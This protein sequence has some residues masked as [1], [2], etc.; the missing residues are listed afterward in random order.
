MRARQFL[1]DVLFGKHE[2]EIL[3]LKPL[4]EQMAHSHVDRKN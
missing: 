3:S 4:I 1:L 2:T